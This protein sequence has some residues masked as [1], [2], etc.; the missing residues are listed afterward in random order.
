VVQVD[1]DKLRALYHK[2]KE[3]TPTAK[4][5]G[6]EAKP[7]KRRKITRVSSIGISTPGG[8]SGAD[9]P[10]RPIGMPPVTTSAACHWIS[11]IAAHVRQ[12]QGVGAW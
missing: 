5:G 11:P 2:G 4:D 7:A 3:Q 9:A 6:S 8:D 1:T 10:E 12:W